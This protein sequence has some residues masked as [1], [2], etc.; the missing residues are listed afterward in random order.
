M[1][2]CA[3]VRR[4]SCVSCEQDGV[5]E[6]MESWRDAMQALPNE[7]RWL[8][9]RSLLNEL[10][11]ASTAPLCELMEGEVRA[12]CEQYRGRVEERP[13]LWG[14]PHTTHF[15]SPE[16]SQR[17]RRP[18]SSRAGGGPGSSSVVLPRSFSP[19][20]DDL[21]P[22]ETECP[23]GDP[24]CRINR[25]I[26]ALRRGDSNLAARVCLSA[27]E[28]WRSECFFRA[29]EEMASL[30]AR[31]GERGSFAE[32]VQLCLSSTS[33]ATEC[34]GQ[35][36][37]QLWRVA[38]P[39]TTASGEPWQYLMRAANSLHTESARLPEGLADQLDG[40]LWAGAIHRSY[41]QATAVDGR[42]LDHLPE[43]IA[44]HVRAAAAMR[45]AK[46]LR[47]E[48]GELG[49]SPE[50]LA[51]L[52]GTLL[53]L[54]EL[55]SPPPQ[56]TSEPLRRALADFWQDD[57]PSE[58]GIPAI[59]YLGISRRAWSEEP[60][61]DAQLTLLEA[62]ARLNMADGLLDASLHHPDELISWTAR[63]L[64]RGQEVRRERGD[65]PSSGSR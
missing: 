15:I 13:H 53:E 44:P 48:E 37:I 5:A 17:V 1:L 54:L 33:H 59:S 11:S 35:A 55:R 58:R 34:I 50:A 3:R 6:G 30:S 42:P 9:T 63:R 2:C 23:D 19:P 22:V 10:P 60:L 8:A 51:E 14:S 43:H 47:E 38:P 46:M 64:R 40:F 57:S 49:E 41:E 36:L 16:E 29:G 28:P 7:E 31:G 26:D 61:I 21:E 32:A 20:L 25:S 39:S 12:V 56:P 65:S 4:G 62:F 27:E 18:T 24:Q 52:G 45:W